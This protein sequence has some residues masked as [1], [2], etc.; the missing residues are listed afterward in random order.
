MFGRIVFDVWYNFDSDKQR[1]D[2]FFEIK[3][4][5]ALKAEVSHRIIKD[6]I[7]V[8]KSLLIGKLIIF[9]GF[10][11]K[12]A[13]N[14]PEFPSRHEESQEY[15]AIFFVNVGISSVFLK[16]LEDFFFA[17]NIQ[18]YPQIYIKKKLIPFLFSSKNIR[19]N[20]C[21]VSQETQRNTNKKPK[22]SPKIQTNQRFPANFKAVNFFEK[23]LKDAF[24]KSNATEIQ[25]KL[26]KA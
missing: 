19:E 14:Q 13:G 10:D 26:V 12:S 6:Q 16:S 8:G 5:I 20:Y 2:I 4:D 23:T 21:A 7:F 15:V 25:V 18:S 9:L 22:L 3:K 11:Q 17:R 24:L 1:A